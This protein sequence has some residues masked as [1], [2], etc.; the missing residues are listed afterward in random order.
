[1]PKRMI[2]VGGGMGI[3]NIKKTKKLNKKQLQ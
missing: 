1:M 3:E 2:L